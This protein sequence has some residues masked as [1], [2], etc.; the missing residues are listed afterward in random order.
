MLNLLDVKKVGVYAVGG[1]GRRELCPFSDVDLLIVTKKNVDL[2]ESI[3]GLWDL[4]IKPSILIRSADLLERSASDDLAFATTILDARYLCGM[5]VDRLSDTSWVRKARKKFAFEHETE[6][7]LRHRKNNG[8][9]C[10]EPNLR[11]GRGGMRDL[12]M[13]R[14]LRHL[15]FD[16]K[17]P[18]PH[19][20]D[21]LLGA[22]IV[23][24]CALAR[25]EDRLLLSDQP[26]INNWLG[27]SDQEA[28]SKETLLVMKNVVRA[29]QPAPPALKKFSPS[30][31]LAAIAANDRSNKSLISREFRRL[32]SL[33]L[34]GTI[35][36]EW[37]R[38]ECLT[39]NDPVHMFTPEEHTLRALERLDEIW[40]DPPANLAIDPALVKRRDLVTLAVL[41]HDVGKG[42][43]M[44]HSIK[45]KAIVEERLPEW[46]CAPKDVE[47]VAFLV[48][49]HLLLS[50]NAFMRDVH[51]PG[52]IHS[53]ARLI[54]NVERLAMLYILTV[55][56]IRA[57][58]ADAFSD[59]KSTLLNTLARRL[60]QQ[61]QVYLPPDEMAEEIL[62]R[63]RES[64][65]AILPAREDAVDEHFN[66]IDA[67]YALAYTPEQIA[68]HIE[69][70]PRL[71]SE[72][73]VIEKTE[74]PE[75][76]HTRI[77]VITRT[78]HG[79]FAEITGA[80]SARG[81][82]ILEADIA[83]RQDGIAIDSFTV[84]GTFAEDRW[85]RFDHDLKRLF[86]KE[87]TADELLAAR[88]PYARKKQQVPARR[89]RP[90]VLIDNACSKTH[91]V[92]EVL[93]PDEMGLLY[94]IVSIFR[95][96]GM[97]ITSA[98]VSTSA[99]LGVDVF[100]VTT[101]AGAKVTDVGEIEHIEI[102]LRSMI[103]EKSGN[104]VGA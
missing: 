46:G 16:A 94:R 55:A 84:A 71:A 18:L 60:E 45:G 27:W 73:F 97:G 87:T 41:F 51:D 83:T 25:R 47:T 33:A 95:D 23:I 5:K 101:S 17:D 63:R 11:E 67:R 57:V 42:S 1:Y 32:D 77:V 54:G 34:I 74:H 69:L 43:G 26:V 22:R 91:T 7:E 37:N 40:N 103:E 13:E 3:A 82:D 59:W 89:K 104:E 92:V 98:I 36:P 58:S 85:A 15:G 64:V 75:M 44:D 56:D 2:S 52:L 61:C 38:V 86:S 28:F 10:Q 88:V 6:K 81:F 8:A 35:L 21:F 62:R 79:L 78:H 14:W 31:L 100:Y 53:L 30:D 4:Q 93:A 65:G 49:Q 72:I 29:S 96:C 48:E 20:Y 99:G 50:H 90:S 39:R 102:M 12:Q 19:H 76:G 68:H 9:G 70:I 80:L 24:H 66:N